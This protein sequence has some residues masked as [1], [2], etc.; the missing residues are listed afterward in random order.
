MD[1]TDKFS[2]HYLYERLCS[3]PPKLQRDRGSV[4]WIQG[5]LFI[6]GSLSL[7]YVA[8]QNSQTQSRLKWQ[9]ETFPTQKIWTTLLQRFGGKKITDHTLIHKICRH[10]P[11]SLDETPS[12]WIDISL[13]WL[14]VSDLQNP[15]TFLVYALGQEI[16]PKTPES[17]L[18]LQDQNALIEKLSQIPPP[19]PLELKNM[20]DP[21]EIR[22]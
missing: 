13:Q 10:L 16:K 9:K 4:R 14:A 11:V 15:S 8:H 21:R 7:G 3:K 5:C 22:Y 19:Q 2:F 18:K 6:L 12:I 1:R 20:S 17:W